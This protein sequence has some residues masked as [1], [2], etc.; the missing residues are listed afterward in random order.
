MKTKIA[1][2]IDAALLATIDERR[3]GMNRSK[4]IEMMVR[5]GMAK[6]GYTQSI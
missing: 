3:H 4:F 1:I 5:E 6:E 2:T